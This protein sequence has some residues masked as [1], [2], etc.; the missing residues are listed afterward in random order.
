[1]TS[2]ALPARAA[3]GSPAEGRLGGAGGRA[4]GTLLH[5][6]VCAVVTAASCLAHVWLAAGNHHGLWLNALMLVMVAV[7]VPCAVH[8]W[9]QSSVSALRRIMASGVAMAAVHAF[10]LLA[11]GGS[12]HSHAAA[13][14]V[15]SAAAGSEGHAATALLAVIALEMTTAFLAS[16]L[17]ARLRPRT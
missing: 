7:C 2:A 17:V 9:R 8:V 6:R 4:A 1:M 5:S 16:T 11:P 3:S 14:P 12:V 15:V 13:A 10:L